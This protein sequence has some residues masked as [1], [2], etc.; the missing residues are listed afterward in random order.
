MLTGS[1]T[2][3]KPDDDMIDA[4]RMFDLNGDGFISKDELCKVMKGL[5]EKLS[6]IELDNL[7]N[8]W[9]MNKDGKIDY[10]EFCAAMMSQK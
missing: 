8:E 4:F 10:N 2:T 9:D 1:S 7:L 6:D 3:S 5:G